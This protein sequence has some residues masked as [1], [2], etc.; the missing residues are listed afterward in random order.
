M[1]YEHLQPAITTYRCCR[2]RCFC[3]IVSA[4]VVGH[5]SQVTGHG[6]RVRKRQSQKRRTGRNRERPWSDT[7]TERRREAIH[8]HLYVFIAP[9]FSRCLVCFLTCI[10][11]YNRVFGSLAILSCVGTILL[12]VLA[13]KTSANRGKHTDMRKCITKNIGE[14]RKTYRHAQMYHDKHRRIEENIPTC[15]NV[16]R[17]TSEPHRKH[18]QK[19]RN[20]TE[21]ITKNIGT[22]P[23]T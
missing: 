5:R 16:S 21:N 3:R 6:S 7:E 15:A 10:S 18:N 12:P 1:E 8:F 4:V 22:P 20:P 11:L 17:K 2:R 13:P 9:Y 14:S 23:K 19:H